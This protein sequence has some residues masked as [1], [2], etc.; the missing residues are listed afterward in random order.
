MGAVVVGAQARVMAGDVLDDE[1][2]TVHVGECVIGAEHAVLRAT[3][4]GDQ[5]DPVRVGDHA[6]RR[7]LTKPW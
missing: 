7:S 6:F 3:G 1:G 5:D 2:S 4:G